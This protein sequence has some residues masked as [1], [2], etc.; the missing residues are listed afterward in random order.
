MA[1]YVLIPGAGGLAAYWN[2]L[3]PEL[4]RRGA[5][6]VAVDLPAADNTAGLTEYAD[7]VVNAIRDRAGSADE[8]VV[9]AQSMGGFTAPLVCARVPV[10]LLVMLN[11]MV[12]LPGEPPAAWWGNTG[13]AQARAEQAARA[14]RS[15]DDPSDDMH[16]AFFHDLPPDV[17]AE[18]LAADEPDQSG[19]PFDKPWPLD[20]WPDVPTRF[21]HGRDDRFFPIEF[22]HRVVGERLG[23]PVDEMPGGHLVALSQP[24]ELADRLERYR[25]ELLNHG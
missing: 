14:G 22:Q 21:L 7:T 13:F 9:V 12:P 2:R 3:E 11:A 20:G 5:E 25:T 8:L 17:T 4:H 10:R 1:T 24:V 6:T 23:L 18:L 19:T 15:F 16:D